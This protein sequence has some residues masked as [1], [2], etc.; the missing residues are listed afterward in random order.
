MRILSLLSCI[1][2]AV[3]GAGCVQELLPVFP[4]PNYEEVL[5]G[6]SPVPDSTKRRIEGVYEVVEGKERFGDNVVLKYSGDV[7]SVFSER[8][9][10]FMLLRGGVRDSTILYTGTWRFAQTESTGRVEVTIP[11]DSG[12]AGLL[13]PGGSRPSQVYFRGLSGGPNSRADLNTE[14]VLRYLRPVRRRIQGFWNIAHRGGGRNSDRHPHSENSIPMLQLASHLGANGVEIDIRLTKDGIPVLFHDAELTTRLVHGNYMTGPIGNYTFDELNTFARL[15]NG[16]AIPTLAEALDTIVRSTDLVLVW[17]DVK[18]GA[19]VPKVLELIRH[20]SALASSLG[21]TVE[22][23]HGIPDEEILAA[24]SAADR[25]G[26]DAIC[27]LGLD[28]TRRIDAS[29][30][31]PRWTLGTLNEEVAAMHAEGRRA[32]VW[33]LDVPA[34]I[35][36]FLKEG[37]FDG[38]LTNYPTLVAYYAYSLE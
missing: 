20:Y 37:D 7:L 2:F 27:E 8:N 38:I 17:L 25:T 24:Y 16:E 3:A 22:I 14:L 13:A 32:F 11:A 29:V 15:R 12:G 28:E 26:A 35:T 33:T 31:A 5:G 34:F 36:T 9:V 23:L 10:A 19:A 30:W 1:V 18:E 21:R 4:Q 6:T